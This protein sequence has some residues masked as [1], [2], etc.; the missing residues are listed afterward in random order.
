MFQQQE[1]TLKPSAV[2]S[3]IQAY[4]NTESYWLIP[5]VNWLAGEVV[6][7]ALGLYYTPEKQ[8][9]IAEPASVLMD[10]PNPFS[11][12]LKIAFLRKEMM[13]VEELRE[14]IKLCDPGQLDEDIDQ[15]K[16]DQAVLILGTATGNDDEFYAVTGYIMGVLFGSPD[17][18]WIDGQ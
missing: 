5:I 17:N 15:L 18:K 9:L 16:P 8:S 12:D 14:I 11:H 7:N 10:M 4:A 3:R 6:D 1:E 2:I 13:G